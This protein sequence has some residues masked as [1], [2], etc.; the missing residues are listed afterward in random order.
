MHTSMIQQAPS[1]DDRLWHF[2]AVQCYALEPSYYWLNVSSH[3][4]CAPWTLTSCTDGG[5]SSPLI[6]PVNY[7]F[8]SMSSTCA[9]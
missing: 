7:F 1:D 9:V 4:S 5:I 3:V 2:V 6:L 8:K